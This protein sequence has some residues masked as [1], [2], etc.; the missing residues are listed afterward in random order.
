MFFL[1]ESVIVLPY[2]FGILDLVQ[3]NTF[4]GLIFLNQLRHKDKT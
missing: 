3:L 4:G 1:P 2:K